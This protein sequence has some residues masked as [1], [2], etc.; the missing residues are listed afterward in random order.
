MLSTINYGAP[1]AA[2]CDRELFLK[3]CVR[4]TCAGQQRNN[5]LSHDLDPL[6]MIMVRA[7]ARFFPNLPCAGPPSF[8]DNLKAKWAKPLLT[9]PTSLVRN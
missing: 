4:A 7:G 3:C 1:L 8:S 5:S 2:N 6:V 9:S